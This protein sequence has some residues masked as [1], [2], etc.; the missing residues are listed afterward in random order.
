MTK[1]VTWCVAA[2]LCMGSGPAALAE[3]QDAPPA[4]L[5][6][7]LTL[8]E[9]Y[10]LALKRSETIA[11]QQELVR[12]TEGRFLQALSTAL[13]EVSFVSVDELRE[14]SE[15]NQ[16]LAERRFTFTQPL[17]S[18]FKEFAAIRGSKA[19]KRQRLRE[20]ARAEQL[21]F[22][23]VSE[24]FYFYLQHQ[25]DLEILLATRDALTARI[26][27][28]TEREELGRARTSE[29]VSAQAQL[30]RVEAD[31]EGSRSEMV[32]SRQLLEFLT[33][34]T[35]TEVTEAGFTLPPIEPEPAYLSKASARPDVRAAEE[36]WRV[37]R[38][39]TRVARAEFFPTVDLE[40]NYYADRRGTRGVSTADWDAAITVDVPLFQGG[41]AV[42]LTQEASSLARQ[43]KLSYDLTARAATLEIQD[44][45]ARLQA[46]LARQA[47]LEASMKA[48]EEDYNLQVE[49]YRRSLVNNLDVLDAL[50]N[51]QDARRLA[52]QA[53]YQTKRLYWQLRVA[54]GETW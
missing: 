37:S 26:Q 49:D 36:A 42:G 23:D 27:E 15:K 18:G 38:E 28:L 32:V 13:P 52:L 33:G 2:L 17:F 7:P 53:Q 51:L 12:Q 11:I 6:L 3:A 44:L 39:N 40:G 8:A 10:A 34:T 22:V 45:Y 21:L 25:Q 46:A 30:R 50:E 29:V 5:Q 31:M 19:E 48:S 43:A 24:A 35:V 47:A 1:P 14:G 4:V 16:H 9:C 54:T 20:K 41:N